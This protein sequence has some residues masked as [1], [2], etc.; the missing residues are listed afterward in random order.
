MIA[1]IHGR[2]EELMQ[3]GIVRWFDAKSGQ[4]M[5]RVNDESIFVHYSAIKVNAPLDK[6]IFYRLLF[7]GQKVFVKIYIDYNWKQIEEVV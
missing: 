1:F 5:I 7:P 6:N 4:G 2:M 3:Q